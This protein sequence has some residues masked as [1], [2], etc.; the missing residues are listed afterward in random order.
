MVLVD[1]QLQANYFTSTFGLA[2]AKVY[3]VPVGCNEDIFFPQSARTH[4]N[5]VSILYYSTY[6][7]LHGVET[8]VQAAALLRSE[9]QFRFRLIG[10]GPDYGRVRCLADNL[11]AQNIAFQ[12]Y[13]PLTNLPA[14]IAAAG[15]CLGGPFGHTG[16]ASRVMPGKIFQILAMGRPLIAADTPAN[17]ELLAHEE[18][19]YLCLPDSPESLA[20]AI[21][22]LYRDAALC[23]HL[24]IAG[25]ALYL[26]KCSEAV[27]TEQLRKLI[28]E[29]IG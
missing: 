16:K 9:S 6:Q 7:P 10:T 3:H 1:T 15:I 27:I 5:A 12:E 25:R 11:R 28:G 4:D 26:E 17:R 13:V 20:S 18:T 21:L 2:H 19:A 29:M 23:E 24:A 8:V 22:T 14:E